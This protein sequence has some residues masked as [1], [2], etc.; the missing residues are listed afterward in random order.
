MYLAS[1]PNYQVKKRQLKIKNKKESNEMYRR[2]RKNK[3]NKKNKN[4][5]IKKRKWSTK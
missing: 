1:Q 3:K 4:K 5:N 2:E